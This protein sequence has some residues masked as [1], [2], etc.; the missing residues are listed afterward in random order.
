MG[1]GVG[2]VC[3]AW[4]GERMAQVRVVSEAPMSSSGGEVLCCCVRLGWHRCGHRYCAEKREGRHRLHNRCLVFKGG[5]TGY[6]TGVVGFLF[7]LLP[8]S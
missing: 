4:G 7:F 2:S 1:T 6:D 5:N 8:F 3:A